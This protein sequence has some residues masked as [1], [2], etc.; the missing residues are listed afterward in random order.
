MTHVKCIHPTLKV[1]F[2]HKLF[3]KV[4]CIYYLSLCKAIL[5]VTQ[6]D[7]I[8]IFNAITSHILRQLLGNGCHITS[9]LKNLFQDSTIISTSFIFLLYPLGIGLTPTL[10][11]HYLSYDQI[12][13][14]YNFSHSM[15]IMYINKW[16]GFGF[17]FLGSN[18]LFHFSEIELKSSQKDVAIMQVGP[19]IGLMSSL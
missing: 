15:P 1:L 18:K 17:G 9:N 12:F 19:W 11:N 5:I 6:W 14:L 8:S 3:E 7:L 16:V 13:S 2:T 4:G 10:K